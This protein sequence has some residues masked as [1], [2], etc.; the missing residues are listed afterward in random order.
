[1]GIALITGAKAYLW[2]AGIENAV[3]LPPF[4]FMLKAIAR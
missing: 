2:S 3:T 4:W 1:M